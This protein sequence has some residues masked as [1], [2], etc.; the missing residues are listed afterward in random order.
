MEKTCSECKETK[1]ISLFAKNK[2]CKDGY[3]AKCKKCHNTYYR[4]YLGGNPKHIARV[5]ENNLK[6]KKSIVLYKLEHG[7]LV[8]GYN[9]CGRSLHFHHRD[10]D[11]KLFNIAKLTRNWQSPEKLSKELNKCDIVCAN[12][13]GEIEEKEYLDSI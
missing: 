4:N 5:N 13:H 12:C 11:Q 8:C 6:I 7:C 10:K 3:R 2:S 9:K 1:D